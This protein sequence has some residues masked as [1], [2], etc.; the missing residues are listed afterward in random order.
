MF[1]EKTVEDGLVEHRLRQWAQLQ[2]V[3]PGICVPR[4]PFLR[5]TASLASE[6]VTLDQVTTGTT[7]YSFKILLLGCERKWQ[8]CVSARFL[9]LAS[10]RAALL[11]DSSWAWSG[12]DDGLAFQANTRVRC[13]ICCGIFSLALQLTLPKSLQ[14]GAIRKARKFTRMQCYRRQ[15]TK[16]FLPVSLRSGKSQYV[17]MFIGMCVCCVSCLYLCVC[18]HVCICCLWIYVCLCVFEDIYCL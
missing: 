10:R 2:N 7:P 5:S 17:S 6:P 3:G 15:E 12:L 11:K 13:L 18:L 14:I 16:P 1:Q 4:Q 9:F 8:A